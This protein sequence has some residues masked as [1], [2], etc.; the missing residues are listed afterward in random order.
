MFTPADLL[1]GVTEKSF[2]VDNN[3]SSIPLDRFIGC[4]FGLEGVFGRYL[5]IFSFDFY[6]VWIFAFTFLNLV[7]YL[8]PGTTAMVL[9]GN[10]GDTG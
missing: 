5:S 8:D 2:V 4:G 1:G 10:E 9:C 7:V 3:T 6:G